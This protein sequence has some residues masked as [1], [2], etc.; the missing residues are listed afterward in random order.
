MDGMLLQFA[1]VNDAAAA[2]TSK[3]KKQAILAE[4]LCVLSDDDVRL[5]LR[6]AA[7]RDFPATDERV[8]SVGW[9]ILS[10]VI[11]PILGMDPSAYHELVVQSGEIGEALR[12]A[13]PVKEVEPRLA[14]RDIADTF[15]ALAKT[16]NQELKRSLVHDLFHRC[17]TK[18]EAAYLAKVISGEMRT[19]VQDGTLLAAIAGAFGK[20][21][22]A[23]QRCHLLVGDLEEVAILARHDRMHDARF[24]LFHPLQF[25][26]ATAQ[27]TPEI[28]VKTMAGRTVCA[29]DKLDGIRAQVHKQGDRVAIYTRTM[30]RTDESF[31]DVVAAI[32]RIPGDV[33]LD[34]EIVPWCDGCVLPFAHLQRRLGRKT[35]SDALL[36][37]NPAAFIA[38]DCLYLNG[39]LLMD[40]PLRVRRIALE[41]LAPE[42][43][44]TTTL[45]RVAT[46]DEIQRIFAAARERRNEGI[47]LKAPDSPYA[48]GRRGQAWLKLKTHLPTLDC[49]ITAAEYGNGKR[50]NSLSD[51]TFAVWDGDPKTPD[52][53]LV[54]I[55]KAYMGVTDAEIAELT[56]ALLKL[57]VAQHGRVHLVEPKI[58]LEI[59]CDQIQQSARHAGGFAMRF[60]RVKRIRHDKLP[61]DA[62]TLAR[63]REIYAASANTA[64]NPNATP[65]EP[66]PKPPKPRPRK[67]ARPPEPTLFDSL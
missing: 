66:K 30:D 42:G 9:A 65:R 5:A 26:L 7:G 38:F 67:P 45:T 46:A 23:V 53:R 22:K 19:G 49:V 21:P 20:D 43:L 57:S 24:A 37:E 17:A 56:E 40:E 62:D 47:I 34:G 12:R 41:S 48:A 2:T 44:M 8:I 27:D 33:L 50:R 54:N 39:R 10:D 31:P 16:G 3:L 29:E 60:P 51:Y 55:G 11:L 18:E 36:A 52:A 4:Y 1:Q 64:F 35:L 15:D 25:M 28:A 14:L 63:V 6:Y 58:V 61:A 59:A 32:R 13:W